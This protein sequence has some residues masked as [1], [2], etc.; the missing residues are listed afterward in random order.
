[1]RA[2]RLPLLLLLI[3]AAPAPAGAQTA[4]GAA[5][6]YQTDMLQL[7]EVLGALHYLRPLCGAGEG[8][9]WREE[10]EA[11]VDA[12]QPSA[13][14]RAG[15]IA[16]FNRGYASYAQVYHACTGSAQLAGRRYLDEGARLSRDIASRYG[17]N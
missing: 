6:P 1:M 15:L 7:A 9:R 14:R 16:S 10:M 3:A 4:E 13:G 5:P 8:A 11:L 2:L 12:E 17:S